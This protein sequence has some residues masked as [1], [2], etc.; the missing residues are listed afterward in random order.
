MILSKIKN[1][2]KASSSQS[3][4]VEKI[5]NKKFSTFKKTY[6]GI[7]I[8]HPVSS[9]EDSNIN[10]WFPSFTFPLKVLQRWC[11]PVLRVPQWLLWY[12]NF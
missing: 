7:N 10:N 8:Q 9:I 3:Q 6:L 4:Q 11:K 2:I 1:S 12:H 5:F